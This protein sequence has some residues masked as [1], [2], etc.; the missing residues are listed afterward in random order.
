DWYA[1]AGALRDLGLSGRRRGA[2]TISMQVAAL[3]DP[4]VRAGHASGA[5]KRKLA[6]LRAAA[7]LERGWSKW[8]I[9]A[10]YLNLLGF[11]GELQGVGAAAQVL[12]GKQPSGLSLPESLVLAALLP[13]PGA[14]T[15]RVVARACARAAA[16]AL[17]TDCAAIRAAAA[18]MLAR[19]ARGRAPA[20][21]HLAPQL[22]RELL[23]DPGERA[24]TTLDGRVQRIAIDALIEQL[25][26]LAAR[27]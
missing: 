19:D 9:L 3:L 26:G 18:A 6:Q 20:S 1:L 22:A 2:S 7:A 27:N 23:H 11:R 25:A 16:R 13:S 21:E 8:E 5:W 4:G 14:D 24:R 15:D 17:P 10:A 12:A